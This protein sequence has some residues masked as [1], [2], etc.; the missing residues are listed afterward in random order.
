LTWLTVRNSEVDGIQEFEALVCKLDPA[1]GAMSTQFHVP[2][3]DLALLTPNPSLGGPYVVG[4]QLDSRTSGPE[5]EMPWGQRIRIQSTVSIDG[6]GE[7][8]E[9]RE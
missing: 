2:A 1:D 9:G 8:L 5:L 7:L 6:R 4:L 3:A